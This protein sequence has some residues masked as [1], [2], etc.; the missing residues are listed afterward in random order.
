MVAAF[1]FI[2]SPAICQRETIL[3]AAVDEQ[4][5]EI[6]LNPAAGLNELELRFVIAHEVLHV[7]LRH[8]N[9]RAGRDALLW[10]V[11]CDYVINGWLI[12]MQV[13][14]AP[15]MGLLHDAQLK[16][17]SAESIYDRLVTDLR[18]A[19]KLLTFAGASCD[20]LPRDRIPR[21]RDGRTTDLDAFY[22]EQ[23]AKGFA[24]HQSQ[25]R[26]LLPEGLLEEIRALEGFGAGFSRHVD[27]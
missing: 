17:L 21:G 22:R 7:A 8:M 26:G 11:A 6:F 9:R 25:G 1:T 3:V 4:S 18:R 12:E 24:L 27:V 15:A 20:M 14:E 10:N 13:G 5:R 23:L 2:E 19:R 16:G